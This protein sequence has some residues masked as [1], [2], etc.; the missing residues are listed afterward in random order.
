MPYLCTVMFSIANCLTASNLIF[1]CLGIVYLFQTDYQMTIIF[2]FLAA[3]ADL[4]DGF[5]ARL[6]NQQSELGKE[7]DSLA[8]IVSFGV[9]PACIAHK[10]MLHF[11]LHFGIS[12]IAFLLAVMAAFRLARYNINAKDIP[13]PYFEGVPVPMMGIFFTGLAY[14][15]N[16]I[17]FS[18]YFKIFILPL[19]LIFSV[20]MI[21]KL[22]IIKLFLNGEW[23]KKNATLVILILACMGLYPFIGLMCISAAV[24]VWIIYSLLIQ[25]KI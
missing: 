4:L 1:G 3:F 18:P 25:S 6:L 21:S 17:N 5:V 11:N 23:I 15:F 9:L 2:S 22:S 7:L 12:L 19:V 8:D 16:D 24:L 14:N 10:M 13:S 20:L